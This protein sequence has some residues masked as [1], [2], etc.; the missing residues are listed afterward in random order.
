MRADR[1]IR[2][3]FVL[4]ARE[5]VTAAQLAEELEVSVAT[6]RR[7]LD[8]LT[9]SGVPVYS[10]PGRGG[11]WRLLGGAR[12]NLTGLT[13]PETTALFALLGQTHGGA[14]EAASAIRKLLAALPAT[15]RSSAERAIGSTIDNG[16][17][18]GDAP[19][20]TPPEVVVLQ[21]AIARGRAVT[22]SYRTSRP[23]TT[24]PLGVAARGGSWYLLADPGDKPRM[25]RVDRIRELDVLDTAASP[26][27]GF[28]LHRAWADSV[29]EVEALR[30]SSTADVMVSTYAAS[31]FIS[32]FGA[33]VTVTDASGDGRIRVEARAQST[34]ALAEQLAGW[35]TA[36]DVL[37]PLDVRR[38]LAELGSKLVEHYG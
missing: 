33:Q 24:T 16:D 23:V 37:G 5:S 28:D 8:A 35:S 20:T 3:L 14:T 6:A 34:E 19:S 10:Q 15:F 36:I 11:G 17:A 21:Q 12:T 27:A 22:I 30:G 29:A 7:D 38:A 1:L 32:R 2:V 31:A 25:Y 9:M 13:E 18:W 26:P 4:Q